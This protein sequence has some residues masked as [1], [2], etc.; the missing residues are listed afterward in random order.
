[1][2][3]DVGSLPRAEFRGGPREK[4]TGTVRSVP[5]G[6]QSSRGWRPWKSSMNQR[7]CR[8]GKKLLTHSVA[9]AVGYLI[10][11][12]WL[13]LRP[14]TPPALPQRG[15]PDRA[16]SQVE[17]FEQFAKD[18]LYTSRR[19]ALLQDL[20][21]L[22]EALQSPPSA[23][24]KDLVNQP[25]DTVQPCDLAK[26]QS[27][28]TLLDTLAKDPSIDSLHFASARYQA[29]FQRMNLNAGVDPKE[30]LEARQRLRRLT[31]AFCR[32]R[33]IAIG[34]PRA[35]NPDTSRAFQEMMRD[36]A[37]ANYEDVKRLSDPQ[38]PFLCDRD[39]RALLSIENW[40]NSQHAQKAL[41]SQ[42]FKPLYME[43]RVQVFSPHFATNLEK[44]QGRIKDEQERAGRAESSRFIKSYKGLMNF[45]AFV[46]ELNLTPRN[47]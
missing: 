28:R 47:P 44:I 32:L 39:G 45:F 25:P 35:T 4:R 21:F 29:L 8:F 26:L 20:L 5:V 16:I 17:Q 18:K 13:V 1:M 37:S 7:L 31:D 24:W 43:D 11:S 22:V 42:E 14:A 19:Q 40:L 15:G 36:L 2:A 30:T 33:E 46:A 3:A 27:I 9:V 6:G 34:M 10:A 23:D 38:L 41:P 12:R